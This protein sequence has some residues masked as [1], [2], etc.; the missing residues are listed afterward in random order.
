MKETKYITPQLGRR[1]VFILGLMF[2]AAI[3]FSAAYLR[4][5]N[6]NTLIS[7]S[8]ALSHFRYLMWLTGM[9]YGLAAG[10]CWFATI[11]NA[12]YLR[13]LTRAATVIVLAVAQQRLG[14]ENWLR[15]LSNLGGLVFFQCML[16]YW[17][18]VPNWQTDRGHLTI[19]KESRKGQF[20]IGDI[21]IATTCIAFLF[22]IAIRYRAPIDP[23]GYWLVLG[24]FWLI[25]PLI[26]ACTA[27]SFLNRG[28]LSIGLL[29]FAI[30]LA[31]CGIAGLTAAEL[32]LI[33][34]VR[35]G[36]PIANVGINASFYGRI[37]LSY[38]LTFVLFCIV[39]KTDTIAPPE[40]DAE[41]DI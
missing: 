32:L 23:L 2:I 1:S 36:R 21:V 38:L 4:N 9:T 15:S 13:W 35:G 37:I 39:A 10:V 19:S 6:T 11:V 14:M 34:S 33:D 41:L 3:T 29:A 16:F 22:A 24:L 8:L 30:L 25:G 17:L 31:V 5:L 28:G 40:T 18:G 12:R 7:E 20:G 27:L 26:A